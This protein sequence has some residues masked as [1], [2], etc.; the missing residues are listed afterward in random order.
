MTKR[1]PMVSWPYIYIVSS[2]IHDGGSITLHV[3]NADDKVT[4]KYDGKDISPEDGYHFYPD[5]DGTLQAVVEHMDG[6]CD[7]II[8]EIRVNR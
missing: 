7:T 6:S 2:E 3:V 5:K 8:K 1:K 4:W